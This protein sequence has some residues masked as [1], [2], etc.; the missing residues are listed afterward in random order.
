METLSYEKIIDAPL[1]RVWDALWGTE[2]YSEWTKFFGPGSSM[3]SDWKVGGKTYFV[4][5]EGEGMV[6]TIDTLDQPNQIIFKHLGMIDK[7]GNE[8]TQSKEVME[9]SGSFEKYILIDFDGKTKLHVEVQTEKDWKDHI[10]KG[11]IKGLEVV[12]ELAENS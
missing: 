2:T 6:S 10:D 3:K 5:A 11:F 1:Q 12:K 9:W 7:Q 8:D 4:N